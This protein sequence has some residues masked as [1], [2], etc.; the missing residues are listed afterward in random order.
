M[1]NIA[2]TINVLQAMILTDKEKMVLTPT[3]WVFDMY[4]VHQGAR[5]IPVELNAP[6]YWSGE[7]GIP[8]VSASASRDPEGKLHLS[9]VN[10]DA[11]RPATVSTKMAGGS[12]KSVTGRVLT[13][14]AIN[15]C[16]TF[17]NP[18]AVKPAEFKDVKISGE[19][20]TMTLPARSV[21]VLEIQ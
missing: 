10:L 11:T 19:Q 15:T 13:A 18:E 20:V 9:I 6:Q 8:A 4:K 1:A 7:N 2:Q 5:S 3:Y 16:N 12:A 21:V 17:E 14:P